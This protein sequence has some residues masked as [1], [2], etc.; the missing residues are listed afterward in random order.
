MLSYRNTYG[1]NQQHNGQCE[2]SRTFGL[3]EHDIYGS[4]RLGVKKYWPGQ[5]GAT[6]NYVTHTADTIRLW[7]RQP[8]YSEEYQDVIQDTML[9][10]YGNSL[11]TPFVTQHITGQKQYELTDH[12]G[13]VLATVSDARQPD[14]PKIPL[15]IRFYMPVVQSASDYYPFGMLMPGRYTSD[16]ATYCTTMTET[17]LAPTGGTR[18]IMWWGTGRAHS[19]GDVELA[20]SYTAL[21]IT[22]PIPLT[23]ASGV[24]DTVQGLIPGYSQE[25]DVHVQSAT[26]EYIA[27]VTNPAGDTVLGSTSLSAFGSGSGTHAITFTPTSTS[28]KVIVSA[29]YPMI[30]G[31]STPGYRHIEI[32]GLTV[33]HFGLSPVNVVAQVCSEDE[34]EYGF[35]GQMKVNE[36]AG[37]GNWYTALHWEYGTREARRKNKDEWHNDPSISPYAV[38]DDNPIWKK[39]PDGDDAKAEALFAVRH[40]AIANS[41]GVFSKGSTN[42]S[43][44]A[45]RFS[46]KGNILQEN[47]S[48][49]GS[50]V[51]ADRHTL[52]QA[53]ITSKYGSDIAK[54]AGDAHEEHPDAIAGNGEAMIKTMT[55]KTADEADEA[56]DL[57]NN[58]IGRSIGE[59]SKGQGMKTVAGKVAKEFH[60][61]GLW[62]S[63]K[64]DDGTYKISKTKISDK[65]YNSLIK[66]Y[67][68]LNDNGNT[69]EQQTDHD[70][71]QSAKQVGQK[72]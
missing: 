13:D 31:P 41:I 16:S 63:Q 36:M 48:H 14:T 12:L 57:S 32:T 5:V 10:P 22:T 35:N 70:L 53:T 6:F 37:M 27:Q 17:V 66:S 72:Y 44:N 45:A 61:N 46:T 68:D 19:F 4:S 65:Q 25:I 49:E 8:W 51:N 58:I 64:Q 7:R 33:P 30:S 38:M 34:Y 26:G 39:D 62:T 43:T 54:E 52:W 50:E 28:V 15:P 42:I 67:K 47:A 9:T 55:F 59:N 69:K 56:A 40:P 11:L 24:T 3:A 21:I 18:D 23:V 29:A 2:Q 71:D 60:D 1:F 20:E